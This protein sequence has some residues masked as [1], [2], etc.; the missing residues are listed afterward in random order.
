MNN[1][2]Y[3]FY[4]CTT[5]NIYIGTFIERDKS[6]YELL[7]GLHKKIDITPPFFHCNDNQYNN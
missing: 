4:K 5:G 7:F 1:F 3:F 2:Y 6:I